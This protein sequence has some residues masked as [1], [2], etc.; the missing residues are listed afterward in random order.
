MKPLSRLIN[1]LSSLMLILFCSNALALNTDIS[2]ELNAEQVN[3][4]QISQVTPFT[5]AELA[6][7]LAPIAL[8]PDTILSHILIAATYPLEII[9]AQ[10]W[11]S[12]HSALT[13]DESLRQVE[14]KHWDPSVKALVP[15]PRILERLSNDLDWVQKLGDAFLQDET[16]VLASIQTLRLKAE[17]AGNLDNMENMTISHE[18]DNI[19]I[20]PSEK[21]VVYVPY[22]DTRV[23]YGHWRWAHHPPVYWDHSWHNSHNHHDY[24]RY[25][26]HDRHNYG[27]FSWHPG[28]NISFNFFFSAVH[29]HNRHIVVL[30]RHHHTSGY[31]HRND[32]I[33]HYNGK[34]WH[35]DPVHRKGAAYRSNIVKERYHSN[36]S[37]KSFNTTSRLKERHVITKQRNKAHISGVKNKSVLITRQQKIT[38]QLKSG[39]AREIKRGNLNRQKNKVTHKAVNKAVH[40]VNKSTRNR[41]QVIQP[42]VKK[43]ENKRKSYIQKNN[44]VKTSHKKS[45]TAKKHSTNIQASTSKRSARSSKS[46]SGNHKYR[47]NHHKSNSSKGQRER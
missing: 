43:S 32:I 24:Y 36:R 41:A 47:Q 17:Q 42:S 12:E 2:A 34:R 22:Y 21:E 44:R 31:Y 8:Y 4:Q 14:D 9:Q 15:F 3:E 35:H 39:Q 30:D 18:D 46:S 37:S 7:I 28:V 1:T 38:R 16:Q 13:A 40:K 10:R 26:R 45:H 23:V 27:L 6:Q 25:N 29:W 19:V 20:V 5:E 33:R 11:V